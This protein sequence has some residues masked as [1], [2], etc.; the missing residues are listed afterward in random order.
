ML[1]E[2]RVSGLGTIASATLPLHPGLTVLTGE[3][4]AGKTMV[5]S[6]L[7]LLFGG[8]ADSGLVRAGTEQALVEGRLLLPPD[9]EVSRRAVGAGAALDE[10]GTLV[11]LRTVSAQG[12]SR[13]SVGGA[14]VPVS[15]LG[16]LA[17]IAVAIHGQADQ[18]RLT[19]GAHQREV[20]DRF[21]G[22]PAAEAL[23]R[24]GE[25]YERARA[26]A[27][28][29]T[30][31]AR[32]AAGA[33]QE[34]DRL[35]FALS[36]IADLG[37]RPAEDVM[38]EASI[39]RL[40]HADALRSAATE[41]Q[42]ALGGAD[43]PEGYGGAGAAGA[44]TM[45][46]AAG[47]ALGA[48]AG[49]DAVLDALTDRIGELTVLAGEVQS[50]LSGYLQR[51][52]ADPAALAAAQERRA[53]LTSLLRAHVPDDPTA[54]ALLAWAAAAADRAEHLEALGDRTA[55]VAAALAE[56]DTD[57]AAA[58]AALHEVRSNA[59]RELESRIAGE[60]VH[61]ALPGARVAIEVVLGERGPAGADE[62]GIGFSAHPDAPL[63]PLGRAASGGELS[64]VMLA[65]EV[66]LAG[67]DPVPT[68]VFDEVDAGVGGAAALEVGSRLAR[69]GRAHQVIVVTHLPQVAAYA[70]RH[71]R[72]RAGDTEVL[73][74]DERIT[75]LARMLGGMA[76][77]V[78]AREHAG[79]LLARAA[80]Q[81]VE[82]SPTASGVL[83]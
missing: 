6:A 61:L 9:H 10:D 34:T 42:R 76:D 52:E 65:V 33:A 62:V 63:R 55:A 80:A 40:G 4:G 77:S 38:L 24:Y 36:R 53:A 31:L 56:A 17:Q 7:A 21:A 18:H 43:D 2:I 25:C 78:S 72:V 30:E 70:E 73:G 23:Q 8:R 32:A 44:Y 12:R 57:L 1:T 41:A 13:A 11:V 83:P 79:E 68:M 35:R 5:L 66:A 60:L 46:A 37:V 48:A 71:I 26:L 69:L 22:R 19:G 20:V 81:R 50:D 45:L 59:A 29:R 54:A 74:D 67:A 47:H 75:E 64:R 82:P 3:T 15:V 16:E 49:H 28:E 51:L 39:A 14:S 27:A 58:A